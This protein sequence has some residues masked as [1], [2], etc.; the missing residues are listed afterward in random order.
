MKR[1]VT[2]YTDVP[3]WPTVTTNVDDESVL[4]YVAKTSKEGIRFPVGSP[5]NVAYYVFIPGHSIKWVEIR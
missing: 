4:G 2:F 1:K 5:D 3:D